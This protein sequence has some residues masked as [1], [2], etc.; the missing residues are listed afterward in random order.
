MT[1]FAWIG[2][3]GSKFTQDI[4]P[5]FECPPNRLESW[6]RR[7]FA[8]ENPGDGLCFSETLSFSADGWSA[9]SS[10]PAGLKLRLGEERLE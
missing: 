3:R 2:Q 4:L 6:P 9:S 8:R 5:G 1:S 10:Y 7:I